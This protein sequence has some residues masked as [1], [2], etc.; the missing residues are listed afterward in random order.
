MS[1]RF[2]RLMLFF[3]LP[4]EKASERREYRQFVKLLKK[5]GFFM[6]QKSIYVKMGIDAQ[7]IDLTIKKIK[8]EVPKEGNIMVLTITEKQFSNI[9]IILGDFNTEVVSTDERLLEL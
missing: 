9:E 3:D 6:L 8:K 4:V 2:M 7:V 5:N 1:Y